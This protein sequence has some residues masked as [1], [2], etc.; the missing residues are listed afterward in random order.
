MRVYAEA[1]YGVPP[2][3]VVGSAGATKYGYD[4]DGRPTLIEEPKLLLNDNDAGKP[5]G[6][7]FM[8]GR[9]P[10]AA[11]GNSLGDREMLEYV[12]AGEGDRL[13][14]LILHDD[15]RREYAYGPAQDLPASTVGTFPQSLYDEAAK[16]G[17]LVVSMRRDWLRIFPFE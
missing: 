6:I 5:E 17:W 14:M 3:Q 12:E 16:Q 7:H 10:K 4:R 15:P 1:V 13:V 9:R 2:E 11:F 8:I